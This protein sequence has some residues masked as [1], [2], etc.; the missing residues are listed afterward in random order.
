MK[1]SVNSVK[2][3]DLENINVAV[4]N[5]AFGEIKTVYE[6]SEYMDKFYDKS[7]EIQW[8]NNCKMLFFY[9]LGVMHG[10]REE[11]KIKK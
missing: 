1:T 9:K 11:R 3:E 10:K 2:L 4:K 6:L 8:K 7:S 5:S